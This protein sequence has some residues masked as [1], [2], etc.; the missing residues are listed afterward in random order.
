M[1]IGLV[2]PDVPQ[3]SETFFNYKIKGLLESGFEVIIFSSQRTKKKFFFEHSGAYKIYEG[4]PVR[5]II[6][7]AFV[8][9][10]TFFLHPGNVRKL[11]FL[12]RKD[13]KSFSESLKAVYINAHMLTQKLDW[14]HFGFAT[15]SLNR[16]NVAKA[17]GARMGVS[18]RGFDI[19]IYPLKNPG[20]YEIL[21][22]NVD[23]IHTISDYLREKAIKLGLQAD[24]PFQ[25][26]TPS[27][28]TLL[29]KPKSEPGKIKTPVNIITIGRLNWIKDFETAIWSMKILKDR[30]IDFVYNIIGTGNEL[31]RLKFAVNQSG[32]N[33]KIF[34]LGKLEHSKI[35][36]KMGE[37]DIYLQTSFEEGFCVSVLEAQATGLLCIV[38]D[39][40]G[41]K[42]NVIDEVTGWI[43]P[44]RNPEAI[45]NKIIEVINF[46]EEKRNRI[47]LTAGGRVEK[48][49]KIEDQKKYFKK[50][51]TE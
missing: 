43:V 51:F 33:D 27:I 45:A 5:Q 14:L 23:K 26:I 32:L 4:K 3:Y 30:G 21:W 25:K 18:F 8:F 36:E 31:E 11:F 1:R 19:N 49:F 29:F 24:T 44:R 13:G 28:D 16:E 48:D 50:F 9:T 20:C 15:M 2:L 46:P 34:F 37:S 10:K 42:E 47:A 38:S 40:N 6:L 22:K 39:A 41:L 35:T 17:I 7:F 12:E